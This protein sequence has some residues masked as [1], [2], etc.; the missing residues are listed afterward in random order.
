MFPGVDVDGLRSEE[1]LAN[2]MQSKWNSA[3]IAYAMGAE[4]LTGTVISA[5]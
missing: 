5:A 4:F 2:P 3:P 1:E